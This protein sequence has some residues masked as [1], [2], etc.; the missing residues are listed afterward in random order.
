MSPFI[1]LKNTL[2][3]AVCSTLISNIETL[4]SFFNMCI[5]PFPNSSYAVFSHFTFS[6]SFFTIML[7][8][9]Y[10][11]FLLSFKKCWQIFLCLLKT[12][13]WQRKPCKCM[14]L[15]VFCKFIGMIDHILIKLRNLSDG[16]VSLPVKDWKV[17]RQSNWADLWLLCKL[18][19]PWMSTLSCIFQWTI[20]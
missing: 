12:S 2:V 16:L 10:Y 20:Y 19:D 5:F 6:F 13:S 14:H 3:N 17:G 9:M 18:L 4:L 15:C 8:I 11:L 1:W 7:R